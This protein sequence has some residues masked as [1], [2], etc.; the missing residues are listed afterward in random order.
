VTTMVVVMMMLTQV[1]GLARSVANFG[2]L[3]AAL[4]AAGLAELLPPPAA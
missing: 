4:R 3:A 1:G 2:E